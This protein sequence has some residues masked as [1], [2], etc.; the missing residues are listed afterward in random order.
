[1][2]YKGMCVYGKECGSVERKNGVL[3]I[4]DHLAQPRRGTRSSAC[5]DGEL[6]IEVRAAKG[7]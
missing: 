7:Q 3:V 2:G 5:I 6:E 1:M 4:K